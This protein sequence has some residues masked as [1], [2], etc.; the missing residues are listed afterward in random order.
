MLRPNG[1]LGLLAPALLLAAALGMLASAAPSRDAL[2]PT[3]IVALVVAAW[4]VV[5]IAVP[6]LLPADAVH[7]TR[8]GTLAAVC[9]VAALAAGAW[10]VARRG[11]K[12][13]FAL[14]PLAALLLP[15]VHTRQN[16]ALLLSLTALALVAL[17]ARTAAGRR[18]A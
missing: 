7:G 8:A 4:A 17:A 6:P 1:W 2:R 14:T 5:A 13:G 15:A 10:L 11:P 18:L 3:W 12:V 16:F 9:V